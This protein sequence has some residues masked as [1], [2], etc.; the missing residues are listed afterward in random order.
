ML[1]TLYLLNFEL[2][3]YIYLYINTFIFIGHLKIFRFENFLFFLNRNVYLL[4]QIQSYLYIRT[5]TPWIVIILQ[6]FSPAFFNPFY[7]GFMY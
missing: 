4:I 1:N 2:D 5:N 7:L 3:Y 6:I